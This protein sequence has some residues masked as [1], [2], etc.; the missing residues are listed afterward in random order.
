MSSTLRK[1]SK[2][3]KVSHTDSDSLIAED[4]DGK[5]K[6]RRPVDTKSEKT[7]KP[8][9]KKTKT[10]KYTFNRS[11]GNPTKRNVSNKY[12]QYFLTLNETVK[13]KIKSRL[14]KITDEKLHGDITAWEMKLRDIYQAGAE[15]ESDAEYPEGKKKGKII[16]ISVLY[17][18]IDIRVDKTKEG[19]WLRISLRDKPDKDTQALANAIDKYKEKTTEY[20]DER[21]DLVEVYLMG[22]RGERF[23]SYPTEV[24]ILDQAY[25]EGVEARL[26]GILSDFMDYPGNSSLAEQMLSEVRT[27][28]QYKHLFTGEKIGNEQSYGALPSQNQTTV[29]EG[30]SERTSAYN[31]MGKLLSM[32]EVMISDTDAGRS[33]G[34]KMMS[35]LTAKPE[36][37]TVQKRDVNS[38]Q[39]ESISVSSFS[40]WVKNQAVNR[41]NKEQA[42]ASYRGVHAQS[43]DEESDE[44]DEK[45][46][47]LS[48]DSREKRIDRFR[49]DATTAINKYRAAVRSQQLQSDAIGLNDLLMM[50]SDKQVEDNLTE[51]EQV[52]LEELLRKANKIPSNHFFI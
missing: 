3:K 46:E 35:M 43:D 27:I 45:F 32:G 39:D 19:I 31:A 48:Q 5:K 30:D 15:A 22:V 34:R 25:A 10:N 40:E 44:E 2:Q 1:N 38:Q 4:T 24:E 17:V 8:P 12:D 36:L 21:Y 41:R 49:A 18:P 28:E 50:T 37:F 26:V 14:E 51:R 23:E 20:E 52:Q 16:T 47:I 11:L 29:L 42:N 6:R 9:K 13:Q 33:N 7:R